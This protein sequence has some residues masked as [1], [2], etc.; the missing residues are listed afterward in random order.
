M[1]ATEELLT[2][3]QV[4]VTLVGFSGLISAF[5]ARTV[6]E[7]E[8]RDLSALAMIASSGAVAFAFSLLPL[9]L[10]YLDLS[11]AALWR[12]CSGLFAVALIVGFATFI[13]VNRRLSDAG[14][15]S[16]TPRL[17]RVAPGM[18]MAVAILLLLA[19]FGVL[20][21]GPAA[22][23]TALIVCVLL[24]ITFVGFMLVLARKQ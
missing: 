2:I 23:L 7:L 19:T 20:P 14:H 15:F 18:L 1:A 9:P 21:P 16:R 3:A 17:N 12:L 11:E 22:Y 10:A 6:T 13:A 4:S 5:R 24:C 8:V